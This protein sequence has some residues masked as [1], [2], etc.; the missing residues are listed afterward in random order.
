MFYMWV[1]KAYKSI[2]YIIFNEASGVSSITPRNIIQNIRLI[3]KNI[4][5]GRQEDAHEFLL[6]ILDAME[7]SSKQYITS[8]TKNF[9]KNCNEDN[10]IQKIFGGK[11]VSS[12]TCL[13]CKKSSKKIDNYLGLSLVE[14]ILI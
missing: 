1:W 9:V 4:R 14:F 10:L 6:Y 5:I 2:L 8:S 3:S 7:K 12:V 13:K 11:M